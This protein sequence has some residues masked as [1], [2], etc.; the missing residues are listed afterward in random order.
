MKIFFILLIISNNL[1][2]TLNIKELDFIRKLSNENSESIIFNGTKF[3]NDYFEKTNM[4]VLD[5]KYKNFYMCKYSYSRDRFYIYMLAVDKK[6]TKS[7]K[8]FC[9]EILD[10]RPEITDHLEKKLQFQ[11]KEY[12]SGFFV[13]NFFNNKVLDFFNDVTR[14]QRIISNEINELIIKN[15]YQFTENNLENN[16]KVQKEIDK[17]TKI[18][19][20]IINNS[21]TN[22]DKVIKDRLNEIVRY[23]IF[24]NDVKNFQ[25]YSCNWTPGNGRDPYVKREKFSEFENI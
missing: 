8:N 25:S 4:S 18:Y 1:Y 11:K 16:K 17:L 5:E 2:S 22:L 24:V 14:D 19:N 3:C 20:K 9:N 13:D 21:D 12:L 23:K 10:S 6:D 7:L 15:R